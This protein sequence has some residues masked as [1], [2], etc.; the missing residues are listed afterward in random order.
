MKLVVKD[1]IVMMNAGNRHFTIVQ[2][3]DGYY[4]AIEDKYIDENGRITEALN[5][6]Q[7]HASKDLA[8]CMRMTRLSCHIDQWRGWGMTEDEVMEKARAEILQEVR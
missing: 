2:N 4:L 5:G 8:N 7:L 1:Y 6:F 3:E